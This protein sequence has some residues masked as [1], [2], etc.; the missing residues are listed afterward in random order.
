MDRDT[1]DRIL[2]D[3]WELLAC[4]DVL[5]NAKRGDLTVTLHPDDTFSIQDYDYLG[6]SVPTYLTA[7]R[8]AEIPQVIAALRIA[9]DVLPAKT[10]PP[11]PEVAA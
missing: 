3:G 9:R 6:R 11:V 8:L 1:I 5:V 7:E 4:W 10:L 2:P